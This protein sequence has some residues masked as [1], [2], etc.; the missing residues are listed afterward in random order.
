MHVYGFRNQRVQ[1]ALITAVNAGAGT[2]TIQPALYQ[3]PVKR[4]GGAALG[5][6]WV[7]S[8]GRADLKNAG[9]EDLCIDGRELSF[10][11]F[12]IS[13]A[14]GCWAKNVRI[15]GLKN[16]GISVSDSAQCEVRGSWVA[17]NTTA[18]W[19][20]NSRA[21]INIA[22][23][24][25]CLV[26]DNVILPNFP[27]I[28]SQNGAI[29]G[30]VFAFNFGIQAINNV[31]FSSHSVGD[32]CNLWEGNSTTNIT[33]DG[34]FGGTS[35]NVVYRNDLHGV[36]IGSGQPH[37]PVQLNRF[38]RRWEI[39][40]NQLGRS[41]TT[42]RYELGRPNAFNGNVSGTANS[43]NGDPQIDLLLTGT[44]TRIADNSYTVALDTTIG[45]LQVG[46]IPISMS[47][48][49]TGLRNGHIVTS[50]SGLTVA[51][52]DDGVNNSSGGVPSTGTAV[53]LWSGQ[54]YGYQEWD[55][56]VWPNTAYGSYDGLGST[57]TLGNYAYSSSSIDVAL[58]STTLPDSLFR[59]SAPSFMSGYNWPPYSPTSPDPRYDAI[60]AGARYLAEQNTVSA[61]QFNPAAGAHAIAQSVTITSATSGA[62]IYYTTDGTTPSTSSSVYSS[63][64]TIA[65]SPPTTLKAYAVKSGMTDSSVVTGVYSQSGGGS[66]PPAYTP[67][68]RLQLLRR[69]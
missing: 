38:A 16:Y 17:Q 27:L 8:N 63:A 34:Y 49:T 39:V 14:H 55:E 22:N 11:P 45:G 6:S 3:T 25:A 4:V 35:D 37:W 54:N 9:F 68:A 62:T 44:A 42:L 40:G 56:A 46:A 7:Q 60:P 61:P 29:S 33:Q 12:S 19:T 69:R 20:G 58:G 1:V 31:S 32:H 43:W 28:E 24:S 65:V 51:L 36:V 67:A 59:S 2:I 30:N 41:G 10:S 53:Q 64:L 57:R 18:G 50:V 21:G 48:G 23:I 52:G 5:M 13:V 47:W 66:V 26:E 15:N